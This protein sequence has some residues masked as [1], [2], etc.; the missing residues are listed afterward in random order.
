MKHL[1]LFENFEIVEP[2]NHGETLNNREINLLQGHNIIYPEW[3]L[4]DDNY[5]Y[6]FDH[7]CENIKDVPETYINAVCSKYN[8]VN[9]TIND[10]HTVDVLGVVSFNGPLNRIPLVFNKVSGYFFCNNN[11]LTTLEGSPKK[12]IG[13]FDCSNNKLTT[14]EGSPKEIGCDFNCS[15]N[16]LTTLEGSP[17]KVGWEFNCRGN[18]LTTLLGSTEEVGGHFDCRDNK[19][20]TLEGGPKEVGGNFFCSRN[21]LR[22][23]EYSGIIK[24]RLIYI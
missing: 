19:L 8:I 18:K 16:K 22:S 7:R 20:T 15:D 4:K 10:D 3:I 5:Y 12:I 9:Y 17:V 23:L 11:N 13:N 1:S 21:P 6:I 24:G 2:I 14:L